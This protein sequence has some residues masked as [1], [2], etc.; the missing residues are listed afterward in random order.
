MGSEEFSPKSLGGLLAHHD[1]ILVAEKIT[2]PSVS[3]ALR[4]VRERS[5]LFM[6]EP[7]TLRCALTPLVHNLPFSSF[8]PKMNAYIT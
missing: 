4:A 6:S 2:N 8:H 5:R 3:Y 7:W 1:V